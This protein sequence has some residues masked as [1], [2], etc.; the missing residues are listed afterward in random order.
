M[1]MAV[2]VPPQFFD[3]TSFARKGNILQNNKTLPKNINVLS[4]GQ[5]LI[6]PKALTPSLDQNRPQRTCPEHL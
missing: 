3:G 2:P 5:P 4:L 6:D 1:S